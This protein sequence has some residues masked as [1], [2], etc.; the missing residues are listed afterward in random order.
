MFKKP[1]FSSIKLSKTTRFSLICLGIAYAGFYFTNRNVHKILENYMKENTFLIDKAIQSGL[2]CIRHELHANEVSKI[3]NIEPTEVP[4]KIQ[5]AYEQPNCV[6]GPVSLIST[7]YFRGFFRIF[8]ETYRTKEWLPI[9]IIKG[10]IQVYIPL[11]VDSSDELIGMKVEMDVPFC[12]HSVKP[13][14]IYISKVSLCDPTNVRNSTLYTNFIE[15]I[16][17]S[18]FY[19]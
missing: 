1:A 12:L 3:L 19:I 2:K 5:L 11:K 7:H 10:K 14:K 8:L 17:N 4:N 13:E 6:V 16:K 18:W 15:F 9:T